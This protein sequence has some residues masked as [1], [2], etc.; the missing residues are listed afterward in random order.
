MNITCKNVQG[1]SAALDYFFHTHSLLVRERKGIF[2]FEIMLCCLLKWLSKSQSAVSANQPN[3]SP[4]L[5]PCPLSAAFKLNIAAMSQPSVP[6]QIQ[7]MKHPSGTPQAFI[8]NFPSD[9][10]TSFL[11]PGL[12]WQSL[13]WKQQLPV[14]KEAG[15]SCLCMNY[16]HPCTSRCC[17]HLLC[18][19][20]P[21]FVH[22]F[23]GWK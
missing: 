1:S 20:N 3:S 15:N 2:E 5:N 7:C 4:A 14:T 21:H 19:A 6:T 12:A 18:Q 17:F 9:N 11:Q 13:S 8:M 23:T 16:L 10:T 22:V